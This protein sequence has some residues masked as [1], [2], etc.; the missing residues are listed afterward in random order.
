MSKTSQ[1][2]TLRQNDLD[3]AA[4]VFQRCL[5]REVPKGHEPLLAIKNNLKR[6]TCFVYKENYRIRGLAWFRMKQNHVELLFICSNRLRRK[7]GSTLMLEVARY[8]LQK[9]LTWIYS[10]VSSKDKAATNFYRSLGFKNYR[11]TGHFGYYVRA[12]AADIISGDIAKFFGEITGIHVAAPKTIFSTKVKDAA[13]YSDGRIH[14]N[15][16]YNP[17]NLTCD[18]MIPHEFFHYVQTKFHV[19]YAERGRES[20]AMFFSAVYANRGKRKGMYIR[21]IIRYLHM[22]KH[23]PEEGNEYALSIFRQN[24][25]SIKKTLLGFLD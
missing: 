10:S 23:M 12:R 16:S 22:K 13:W 20:S 17:E 11:K 9:H 3:E 6:F 7:I 19:G 18:E 21:G 4:K 1:V 15:P 5:H 8:A 25:Y 14:I 2:V 24:R